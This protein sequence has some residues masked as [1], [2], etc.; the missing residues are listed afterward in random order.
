MNSRLY[1]WKKG[2]S[3]VKVID[4]EIVTIG[5]LPEVVKDLP[6]ITT[7]RFLVTK[8]STAKQGD[9]IASIVYRKTVIS[10]ES[11]LSGVVVELNERLLRE[12]L[13]AKTDP[14]NEGWLVRIKPERLLEELKSLE[15][16]L[17]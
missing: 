14:L 5:V 13:L 4:K 9:K 12:P 6:T 17:T 2:N 16:R 7:F 1:V 10:V 15:E 8:G 11:P 3:Y